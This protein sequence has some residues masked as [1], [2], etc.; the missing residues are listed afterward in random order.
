[1]GFSSLKNVGVG[2]TE[3][4]SMVVGFGTPRTNL[5]ELKT[6]FFGSLDGCRNRESIKVQQTKSTGEGSRF[7]MIRGCETPFLL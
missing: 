7:V 1:M 4:D 6:F 3:P 2:A 5:T